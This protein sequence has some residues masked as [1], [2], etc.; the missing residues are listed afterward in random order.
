MSH[1]PSRRLLAVGAAAVL[2]LGTGCTRVRDHKG[3]VVDS[4][5]IDTVRPGVDNRD[6][7]MKVLGRPSFA[8]DFD[9]GNR[10]YYWSRETRALAFANPKPV[11]QTL[12]A[13]RFD[14]A[15]N[16]AGVEKTGLETVAKVSPAGGRTPT[17]G[18]NRS[19][20]SELFGNIGRV[21]GAGQAGGTADNPQ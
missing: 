16:V 7:V 1:L 2:L 21:G 17:L 3:Y 5:L 11:S 12:L 8:S 18:R 13:V 10:W 15:G 19:F 4:A 14:A 20:L 9:A 6:S